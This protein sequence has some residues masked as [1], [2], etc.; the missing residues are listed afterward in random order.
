MTQKLRR[1]IGPL[2]RSIVVLGSA[3]A[4]FCTLLFFADVIAFHPIRLAAGDR[5]VSLG[6]LSDPVVEDA[7][8]WWSQARSLENLA[9]WSGGAM[10]VTLDGSK[11]SV[12]T[13]LVSSDF[14]PILEGVAVS[15]RLFL[16]DDFTGHGPP[17]V[18]ISENLWE[19]MFGRNTEAIG[20]PI[21]VGDTDAVVVGVVSKAFVNPSFSD[22]WTPRIPSVQNTIQDIGKGGRR[23]IG[24]IS[25]DFSL[26][27]AED[28]MQ[29]LLSVMNEKYQAK[30]GLNFGQYVEISPL[31]IVM[32]RP[33]RGQMLALTIGAA[34]MVLLAW[35]NITSIHLAKALERRKEFAIQVTLGAAPWRIIRSVVS[36][37][38]LLGAI[39]GAVGGLA[40]FAIFHT[41]RPMF[42]PMF[43]QIL[44]SDGGVGV[45]VG[46]SMLL[47]SLVA[48][49]S[50]LSP[51]LLRSLW[52]DWDLITTQAFANTP[53]RV[54]TLRNILL[55]G[56]IALSMVIIVGAV[57]ATRTFFN[58]GS[59]NLGFATQDLVS[60][61][62]AASDKATPL[63]GAVLDDLMTRFQQA[64]HL[65][66]VAISNSFPLAAE[67]VF[68]AVSANESETIAAYFSVNEWY[69]DTMKIDILSGR[70]LNRRD[71]NS[72]VISAGLARRL[73]GYDN[74]VGKT[75]R[76]G[77]EPIIRRIVGLAAD[78]RV[79]L[80]DGPIPPQIY[81]SYDHP[82]GDVRGALAPIYLMMSLQNPSRALILNIEEQVHQSNGKV[83][84]TRTVEDIV[85][86]QMGPARLSAA[87]G[88]FYAVIAAML[89]ISGCYSLMRFIA[90]MR[91]REMAL[92][93][94]LGATP[95]QV[96]QL[97]LMSG[98]RLS[99]IGILLGALAAVLLYRLVR[100]QL[101]GV[102]LSD[103]SAYAIAGALLLAG[104]ALAS[105]GPALRLSRVEPQRVLNEE[106]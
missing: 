96:L 6:G 106:S 4:F 99:G 103:P 15:G 43:P 97:V 3:L 60:M 25:A 83:I 23:W 77:G 94:A 41:V 12:R 104:F 80:R 37:A 35:G 100:S 33:Y 81:V 89:S 19:T 98:L 11:R 84:S 29:A 18:V 27:A 70:K 32:G 8:H 22:L 105:L 65:E 31:R 58:L 30:V 102:S 24:K 20:S 63:D 88:G 17:P 101:Y 56:Q 69:F 93:L 49:A 1:R 14:F 51:L 79:E 9:L 16:V 86:S 50:A 67:G 90:A 64:L 40:S 52:K 5:V 57:M 45:I 13:V 2:L 72:V 91:A 76:I 53:P 44:R 59:V 21:R 62:V 78:I 85:A 28:E 10:D 73:F 39:S 95:S 42:T 92:R 74:P 68:L 71:R 66:K 46:V 26:A 54:I 75:L 48:M 87:V 7:L 61:K 34:M 55:V 47:G 38:F 82:Y 36:E